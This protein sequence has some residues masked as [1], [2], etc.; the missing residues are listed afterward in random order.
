MDVEETT[1]DAIHPD[2]VCTD[3]ITTDVTHDVIT[4]CGVCLERYKDPR[5]LHC[6][7]HFCV[8][9]LE[10]IASGHPQ[11]SVT[12]PNC[13]HLTEGQVNTLGKYMVR[14]FQTKV[15]DFLA[16][17]PPQLQKYCGFCKETTAATQSCDTCQCVF[18]D[19]CVPKHR[20]AEEVTKHISTPISPHQFCKIHPDRF[21]QWICQEC[22]ERCCPN[23]LSEHD[24]H[25]IIGL[26]QAAT[27]TRD[28]LKEKVEGKMKLDTDIKVSESV[29]KMLTEY[30]TTQ[31]RF[32]NNIANMRKQLNDLLDKLDVVEQETEEKMKAE[33]KELEIMHFD[34]SEF[35]QT[36]RDLLNYI[37]KL[38]TVASDA[39]LVFKEEKYPKYA[40][41]SCLDSVI[42]KDADFPNIDKLDNMNTALREIEDDELVSF[43]RRHVHITPLKNLKLQDT[44]LTRGNSVTGMA[45]RAEDN[46]LITRKYGSASVDFYDSHCVHQAQ[47]IKPNLV[48]SPSD[49]P[50]HCLHGVSID[51]KRDL[52]LLPMVD[53]T[54]VTMDTDSNV[55]DTIKVID[56]SLHGISYSN[57]G[58]LY[59]TS[60][61]AG[62]Y[63]G[64]EQVYVVDPN[65]KQ[66]LETFKPTTTFMWPLAVHCGIYPDIGGD[67][68]LIL[69]ADYG[70]NCIKV[71]NIKGTLLHTYISKS[72]GVAPLSGPY[73]MCTD[74]EGRLLVC[75]CGNKRVVVALWQIDGTDQCETLITADTINDANPICVCTDSLTGKV[76]IGCQNGKILLFAPDS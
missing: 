27:M 63:G 64:T 9:C 1:T 35:I 33:M 42:I 45:Y 38:T 73:G 68:P 13:R 23:C 41:S 51:T 22:E 28:R 65:T 15:T 49:K 74:P 71:L 56:A 59:V 8:S 10:K 39:E 55:K 61:A 18:C 54:L 62:D 12:C 26:Q 50:N 30:K 66:T 31:T 58:D 37:S 32:R 25:T 69:V 52:Y 20:L 72:I 19:V 48:Q 11:G 7:H 60:S 75:D 57:H 2:V 29:K 24:Q 46:K 67:Q 6:G 34:V 70:H 40:S 47:C 36:K 5:V 16:T 21:I 14:E 53:G 4:T 17:Q 43:A 3:V 44:L 76:Y